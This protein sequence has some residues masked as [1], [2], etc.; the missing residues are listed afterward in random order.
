MHLL[1]YD[2]YAS[3]IR[4]EYQHIEEK[5]F[6][7]R[8]AQVHNYNQNCCAKI[9]IMHMLCPNLHVKTAIESKHL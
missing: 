7:Q 1:E 9:I 5:K 3:N 4:L 8:R 2:K 6:Y